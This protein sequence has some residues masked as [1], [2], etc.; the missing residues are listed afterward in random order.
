MADELIDVLRYELM[1]EMQA[2]QL[3]VM[4]EVRNI[5]NLVSVFIY[6]VGIVISGYMVF[7]LWRLIFKPI[8]RSFIKFSI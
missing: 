3:Q 2:N 8:L 4:E 7:M 5:S 6:I 1:A